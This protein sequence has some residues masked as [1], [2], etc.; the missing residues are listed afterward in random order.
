MADQITLGSPAQR[1]V[2]NTVPFAERADPV[3]QIFERVTAITGQRPNL[4]AGPQT[5]NARAANADTSAAR[6]TILNTCDVCTG[7][8]T[9][10]NKTRFTC[11]I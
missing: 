3:A 8:A 5:A 7:V 6:N 9:A 1:D 10:L 4:H 2:A 11:S